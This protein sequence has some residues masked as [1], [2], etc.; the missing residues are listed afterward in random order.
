MSGERRTHLALATAGLALVVLGFYTATRPSIYRHSEFWASSPT[1]FA[2]R[3][4]VMMVGLSLVYALEAIAARWGVTCRP[5]ERFGR[6][7]LFVYWIHVELVYGYAS[8][9]WRG[10]LPLWGAVAASAVFSALM[11]GAV[12]LR[13]RLV[14][15]WSARSRVPSVPL[16]ATRPVELWSNTL[17]KRISEGQK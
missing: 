7:S 6:S 3:V 5:L 2:I 17:G 13:D 1:W 12:I 8:W 16:P 4:G 11:Y 10:R 9:A 15:R 14:E